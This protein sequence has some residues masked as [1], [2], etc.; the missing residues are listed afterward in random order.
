MSSKPKKEETAE[1]RI[2]RLERKRRYREANK[3]KLKEYNN[4]YYTQKTIDKRKSI[5]KEDDQLDKKGQD[6]PQKEKEKISLDETDWYSARVKKK[7]LMKTYGITLDEYKAMFDKQKGRCWICQVRDVDLTNSLGVDHDHKTGVVRGLLCGNCN[8]G[9]GFFK[10][11]EALLSRANE[12][13][14][15]SR[16]KVEIKPLTNQTKLLV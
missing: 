16:E 14:K 6:E 10:D 5:K 9:L 8:R 12:Y 15:M 11:D 3:K 2:K 4:Q 1:Q 7:H 13:L